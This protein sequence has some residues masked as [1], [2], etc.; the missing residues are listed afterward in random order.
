M[1]YILG[2]YVSGAHTHKAAEQKAAEIEKTDGM[3]EEDALEFLEYNTFNTYF[4]E[5]TPIWVDDFQ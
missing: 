2:W 4:G 1:K 3:D 5:K